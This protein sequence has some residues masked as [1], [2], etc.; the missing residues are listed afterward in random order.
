MVVC[1]KCGETRAGETVAVRVETVDSA[2]S[3]YHKANLCWGC[4][5][6][7]RAALMEFLNEYFA[8]TKPGLE[9]ASVRVVKG[10]FEE[11]GRV[12]AG[13]ALTQKCEDVLDSLN[14]TVMH[15]EKDPE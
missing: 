8:E 9:P 12:A 4:D 10:R 15:P 6:D 13:N 2:G 7:F 3:T 11:G 1:E 5:K 14:D